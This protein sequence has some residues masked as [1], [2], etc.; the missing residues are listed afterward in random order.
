MGVSAGKE[1]QVSATV[2]NWTRE[3]LPNPWTWDPGRQLL[4]AIRRYQSYSSETDGRMA[5]LARA[6][7]VA[8]YRFW[9]AVAGADIPLNSQLGGG[10]LLPHPNGIVLHPEAVIGPNCLLFQQVTLGK[11]PKPGFPVL[12]GHVDVG[13]GAKILGGVHVGA[14]AIIGANAVVLDDVPAG[15]TVVGVPAKVV[16][17]RN[18]PSEPRLSPKIA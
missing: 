15:A 4:S 10:L 6:E 7:A 17:L 5:K 8:R 11:G 14:H 12:E 2:A 18:A 16:K 1:A 3:A 13:A 9:S